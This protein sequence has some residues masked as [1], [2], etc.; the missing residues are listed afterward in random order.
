MDR[1]ASSGKKMHATVAPF[2][3]PA[4]VARQRG[5]LPCAISFLEQLLLKYL[6]RKD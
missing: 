3:A 4:H 6:F 2:V 5:G 1:H